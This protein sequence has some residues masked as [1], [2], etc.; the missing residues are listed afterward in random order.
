[1]FKSLTISAGFLFLFTLGVS[2]SAQQKHDLV[3]SYLF[4]FQWGGSMITLKSDGTHTAESSDCTGVTTEYGPYFLEGDVLHLTTLKITR[5]G[6]GDGE[7]E[8]DLTKRKARKEHLDTDEPFKITHSELKVVRWGE[9][10]YL[11]S[12]DAL[13]GF[14]DAINLGFEPRQVDGYRSLYGFFFLRMGD[15]AKSAIGAPALPKELLN[16]LLPK[17]ITGTVVNLEVVDKVTIATINRGSSDG[18]RKGMSLV[19]AET[20]DYYSFQ[21]YSIVSVDDHLARVE[22]YGE[23]LKVGDVVT[24]RIDDEILR[25]ARLGEFSLI[26]TLS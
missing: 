2:A 12:N 18:L 17:P 14:I 5:R 3:G 23:G 9:R 16:G 24:T 7:K 11:M 21:S 1:M 19:K 8:I 22:V 20:S 10:I 25:Y 26:K 6:F 13:P 15:E 4:R